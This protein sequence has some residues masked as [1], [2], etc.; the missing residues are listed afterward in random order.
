MTSA[1]DLPPPDRILDPEGKLVGPVPES[2]GDGDLIE[3]YRWMVGVRTFDS[4]MV[5]LQRQGR[6]AFYGP[7]TGQ[8]AVPVG[9]AM[10][11]SEDDWVVPALR[12]QVIALMRGLP[13]TSYVAQLMGNADDLCKGRQMPCHPTWAAGHYVSMSSVIATQIPHAVGVAMAMKRRRSDAVCLGFFG[14]GATSEGDFHVAAN[15]AAVDRAPIVLLCQNNQW[16]ITVPFSI[17]TASASIATKAKAYG[18]P[19][20]RVDGN[21][22]LAVYRATARAVQRARDGEGP[23]LIEAVTYRMLGHTTSDDPSRYREAAEVEPWKDRDPLDRMRRF[24]EERGIW[25]DAEQETLE[26][27][28]KAE[29]DEAVRDQEG[30]PAPGVET[31]F[32]D[33]YADLPK[34]L[35]RQRDGLLRERGIEAR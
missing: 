27:R 23:T 32:E 17:Q 6:I 5:N 28:W 7:T 29:I 26:S 8:E 33:V 31:L 10:A 25:N 15:F 24:L 4:R 16:A 9:S 3:L 30:R 13:L 22:V 18:M 14:D 34:D 19:F 1:P 20:E 35:A 2:L 11:L 21:D 12:E